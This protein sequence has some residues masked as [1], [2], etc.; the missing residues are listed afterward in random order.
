MNKTSRDENIFFHFFHWK[1]KVQSTK[2]QLEFMFKLQS[3]PVLSTV[4]RAVNGQQSVSSGAVLQ[5]ARGKRTK[6]VGTV[7]AG[8]QRIITQLSVIS[9]RKKAPRLIKLSNEDLIRHDTVQRAWALYQKQKRTLLNEQLEKQYN[10]IMNTLEDLK[11]VSPELY[12]VANQSEKGKRWSLS[13]RVPTDYPANKV[14][15]YDV[16]K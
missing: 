8:T 13:A 15:N 16:K 4:S 3:K 12:E 5:F 10:S 11:S 2:I 9:Q 7:S 6:R 1:K 14:W